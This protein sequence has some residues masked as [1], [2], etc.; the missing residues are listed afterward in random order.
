MN[1]L[2]LINLLV[3]NGYY[4]RDCYLMFSSASASATFGVVVRYIQRSRRTASTKFPAGPEVG[5]IE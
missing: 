3:Q 1:S 2:N 5:L 4:N